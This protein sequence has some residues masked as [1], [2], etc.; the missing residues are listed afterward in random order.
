MHLKIFKEEGVQCP[1]VK[2]IHCEVELAMT[3]VRE[4]Q[5]VCPE[6]P[7]SDYTIDRLA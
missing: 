6:M 5:Q 7:C 4:H 2:C 1:K 3:E